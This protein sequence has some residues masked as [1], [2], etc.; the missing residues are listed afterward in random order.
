VVCQSEF[1]GFFF[2][3]DKS[4]KFNGFVCSYWD[5]GFYEL[6][7]FFC[8]HVVITCSAFYPITNSIFSVLS[9]HMKLDVL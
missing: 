8:L 2:F 5:L 3:F 6:V 9:Q 4:L 7:E 1:H